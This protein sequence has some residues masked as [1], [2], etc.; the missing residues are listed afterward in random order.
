MSEIMIPNSKFEQALVKIREI[1]E[2]VKFEIDPFTAYYLISAVKIART[3]PGFQGMMPEHVESLAK[4]VGN[5]IASSYPEL[6]FVFD[7]GWA[8][9]DNS[10]HE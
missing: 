4:N 3:H 10:K 5:V 2:P 7:L 9:V 1:K 6:K 8:W